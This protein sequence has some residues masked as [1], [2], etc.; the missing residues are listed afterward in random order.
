LFL[1]HVVDK[2][3][4]EVGTHSEYVVCTIHACSLVDCDVLQ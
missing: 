2:L 4:S 3:L 1:I